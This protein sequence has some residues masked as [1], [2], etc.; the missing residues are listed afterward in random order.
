MDPKSNH[1]SDIQYTLNKLFFSLQ[2]QMLVGG[3][4]LLVAVESLLSSRE[5]DTR[6]WGNFLVYFSHKLIQYHANLRGWG[7]IFIGLLASQAYAKMLV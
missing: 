1:A 2:L 4:A 7:Y 5:D 6:S 3:F